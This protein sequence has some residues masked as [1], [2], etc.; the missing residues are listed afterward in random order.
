MQRCRYAEVRSLM[1]LPNSQV[2][3]MSDGASSSLGLRCEVNALGHRL[4]VLRAALG[5]LA[6]GAGARDKTT[7]RCREEIAGT[8]RCL[9]NV[10]QVR[11][12][13]RIA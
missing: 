9:Q 11:A 7:E 13:D 10:K 8:E 12:H 1:I 3:D 6:A 4:A 5:D 2:E